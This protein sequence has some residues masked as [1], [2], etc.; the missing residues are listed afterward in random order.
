M[1]NSNKN[2]YNKKRFY[3]GPV[4]GGLCFVIFATTGL[5]AQTAMVTNNFV[6]YPYYTASEVQNKEFAPDLVF[7]DPNLV[8]FDMIHNLN[9]ENIYETL[10]DLKNIDQSVLDIPFF[11]LHEMVNEILYKWS[12]KE[13]DLEDYRTN[14]LHHDMIILIVYETLLRMQRMM[15]QTHFQ[16]ELFPKYNPY[17]ELDPN[18]FKKALLNVFMFEGLTKEEAEKAV[19]E[20]LR[21]TDQMNKK[22]YRANAYSLEWLESVIK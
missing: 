4:L 21:L 9:I 20:S 6:W 17:A 8:P 22:A 15:I 14:Y 19:E 5:F 12:E 11:E 10:G 7:H 3:V 13:F 2:L 1:I 16:R 18:I